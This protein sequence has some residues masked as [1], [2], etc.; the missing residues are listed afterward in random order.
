MQQKEEHTMRRYAP[1]R[2]ALIRTM[3]VGAGLFCL[4]ILLAQ[5]AVLSDDAMGG[6]CTTIG[7]WQAAH[8]TCTLSTGVAETVV[9]ASDDL[10]L[11]TRRA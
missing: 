2:T 8:K 4:P 7:L 9:I 3:L 10:T 11:T 6:D 1:R 5:A